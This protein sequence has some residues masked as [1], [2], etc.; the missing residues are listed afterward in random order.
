MLGGHVARAV[1]DEEAKLC[2]N[3]LFQANAERTFLYAVT[4]YI[5]A[6]TKA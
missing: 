1:A 6:G 2:W 5:V 4:P 3:H